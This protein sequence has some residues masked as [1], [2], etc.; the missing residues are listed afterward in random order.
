M[1]IPKVSPNDLALYLLV[2]IMTRDNIGLSTN[3]YFP[4]SYN[5]NNNKTYL[6]IY[7][8]TP[9]NKGRL[10]GDAQQMV[11]LD[12]IYLGQNCRSRFDSNGSYSYWRT[13]IW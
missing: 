4:A 12:Y 5:G 11:L 9:Y 13:Y 7:N 8:K 1:I 3:I 6:V 10:S 2:I